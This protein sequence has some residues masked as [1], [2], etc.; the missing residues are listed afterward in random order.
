MPLALLGGIPW[1]LVAVIGIAAGLAFG[2]MYVVG[3]IKSAG[4]YQAQRDA[5]LE[6][7][8]QNADLAE[9]LVDEEKRRGAIA[10]ETAQKK[11]AIRKAGAARR[12][13]IN[14]A[15]A[16][17]DGPLAPIGQRFLDSLQPRAED[18]GTG[19]PTPAAADPG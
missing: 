19:H 5:A 18:A 3:V 12:E 14:A 4:M 17:D 9:W 7:S 10:V 6:A 15:P 1:R 8:K 11:G 16:T 2:A 13:N